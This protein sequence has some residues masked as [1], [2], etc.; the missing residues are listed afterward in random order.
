MNMLGISESEGR[1]YKSGSSAAFEKS[2]PRRGKFICGLLEQ[3]SPLD[4][5]WRSR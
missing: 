3:R 1:E 5:G 4:Y 2:A